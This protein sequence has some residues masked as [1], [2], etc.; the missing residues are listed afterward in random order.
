MSTQGMSLEEIKHM[1]DNMTPKELFDY[2]LAELKA[3]SKRLVGELFE[4]HTLA[5]DDLDL[6]EEIMFQISYILIKYSHLPEES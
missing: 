4:Q 2:K 5:S 6:Q 3:T 1:E